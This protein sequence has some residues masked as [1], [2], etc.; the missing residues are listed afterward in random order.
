MT[1]ALLAL[2]MRQ[3][4]ARGEL[5]IP[6]PA[7]GD[8]AGRFAALM[9]LNLD[10]LA[11]GRVAEAHV[12]AVAILA[13]AG[14]PADRRQIMGVWAAAFD[15][16]RVA[17]EHVRGRWRLRGKRQWCSGAGI[18]DAALVTAT[19]PEGSLLFLVALAQAGVRADPSTWELTRSVPTTTW[20]P[21]LTIAM[22]PACD[23]RSRCVIS[24]NAAATEVI[25]RCGRHH[26]EHDLA[27]IGELVCREDSAD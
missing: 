23:G 4:L 14:R 22:T 17:A 26:C 7:G 6:R 11:L 1:A 15:D 8:T 19:A 2:R 18:V 13:E 12:D 27:L 3:L 21:T 5:D 25:D 10:D 24:S 20:T 9:A 16:S